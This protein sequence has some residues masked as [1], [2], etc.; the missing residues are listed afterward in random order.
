M[1]LD[2]EDDHDDDDDDDSEYDR[3]VHALPD[4]LFVGGA[5]E[6]SMNSRRSL[7]ESLRSTSQ[8]W[9][10]RMLSVVPPL[11]AKSSFSPQQEA[12]QDSHSSKP[13]GFDD[14]MAAFE[15]DE[16]GLDD[17]DEFMKGSSYYDKPHY[18]T[19]LLLHKQ[20]RGCWCLTFCIL[21]MFLSLIIPLGIL[22]R[23][24]RQSEAAAPLPPTM[25]PTVDGG[26]VDEVY[27]VRNTTCYDT[28]TPVSFAFKQCFPSKLDWIG[29][30]PSNSVYY[31]RLWKDYI[32]WIWTCG[33]LPCNDTQVTENLPLEGVIN[34]PAMEAGNY[35]IFLVLDSRWPYRYLANTEV[36]TVAESCRKRK[37]IETLHTKQFYI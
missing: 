11:Q 14:E 1:R 24:K 13:D 31:G 4:G 12:W 8:R 6:T 2:D 29:L 22:A 25:A 3:H 36:F 23:D 30:Y 17:D 27:L 20:S 28:S 15:I 37:L 19:S 35:Q 16:A 10:S 7:G 34:A 32:N 26:C 21:L 33:S 9:S 5:A 18:R